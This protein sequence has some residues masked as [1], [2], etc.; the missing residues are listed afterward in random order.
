[1]TLVR[2][3]NRKRALVRAVFA[4]LEPARLLSRNK[5]LRNVAPEKSR[6]NLVGNS[7]RDEPKGSSAF[8]LVKTAPA[9]LPPV[10]STFCR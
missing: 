1:M 2:S 4:K 9:K 8:K 10:K 6:L 5:V 3:V 7:T